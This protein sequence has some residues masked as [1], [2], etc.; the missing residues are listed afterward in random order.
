[1]SAYLLDVSALMALLWQTHAHNERVSVWQEGRDLAVCPITELG[2][3]RI[4]TQP[5]FGLRVT[6]ARKAL[7]EWKAARRPQF[8]ACDL[9]ALDTD[10]PSTG[11]HT[12]DF[13]LASLAAKHGMDL[14]TLDEGIKH[15][16][17]FLIPH[18]LENPPAEPAPA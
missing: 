13:Y 7:K 12:T 5:S 16:A 15:K 1:M 9:E 18:A 8:C 6:D 17:A 11:V 10:A 3:L 4:S 2:F 14:A